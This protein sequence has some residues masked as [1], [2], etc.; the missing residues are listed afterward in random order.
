MKRQALSE[1]SLKS[2]PEITERWA[3]DRIAENPKILG[4]GDVVL[5]EAECAPGLD[6]KYNMLYIRHC[7]NVPSD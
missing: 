6:L 1:F 4:L 7:V 3:E 5:K 2:H